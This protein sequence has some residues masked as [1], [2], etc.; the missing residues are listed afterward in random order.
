MVSYAVQS[1]QKVIIVEKLKFFSAFVLV[2]LC[3]KGLN[4]NCADG[5]SWFC[6]LQIYRSEF[7]AGFGKPCGIL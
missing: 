3:L 4:F 1:Y 6:S 7:C 2:V 5:L